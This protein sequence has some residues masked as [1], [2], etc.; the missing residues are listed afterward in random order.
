M[1]SLLNDSLSSWFTA[2][3]LCKL[4]FFFMNTLVYPIYPIQ[5]KMSV[6][7]FLMLIGSMSHVDFKKWPVIL[8]NLRVNGH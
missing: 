2:Y 3:Q 5:I 6:I 1:F 4:S 8:T 7:S